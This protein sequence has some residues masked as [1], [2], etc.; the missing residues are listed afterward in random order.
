MASARAA[1]M[2]VADLINEPDTSDKAG[3]SPAPSS[4]EGSSLGELSGDLKTDVRECLDSVESLGTF[5]SFGALEGFI[6]PQVSIDGYP[7]SLPLS[8]DDAQRI[9]K[10]SHKAPFG[11]GT[12]TIVDTSVR[13]TWEINSENFQLQNPEWLHYLRSILKRAAE[14]LG[15]SS[16]S[17]TVKAELYKMLLYE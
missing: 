13:N 3:G 7:I 1:T 9:I 12:E 2:A 15:V 16:G 5:A 10:A 8:E 4:F 17:A 11:K 6:D 14:E